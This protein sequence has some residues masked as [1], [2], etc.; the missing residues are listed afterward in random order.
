M[1]N[2]IFIEV[3]VDDKGTL[4]KVALDTKKL[5]QALNETAETGKHTDR[6]IKGVAQ[7]SSNATKNFSKMSQG[8]T[9]GLVPAYA[10][11]AA[12]VFALT[13]AFDF[14]KNAAD[15]QIMRQGQLQFAETTGI[16][17]GSLTKKLQ[18]A[19]Q[20]MLSFKE[21]SQSAA[22]G[23]AIGFSA[24]Q[25]EDLAEGAGKVATA[26]GRSY[27]DSYDRLVRGISKAEPE[28][29]D[30]LGITLKL[31]E[32]KKNYAKALGL[33][34]DSLN[35][36]QQSQAVYLETMTKL[37]D[38]F[39]K[40][41]FKANPFV[42]LQKTFTN[43]AET[44]LQKIMPGLS[45]FANFL[46][47]NAKAAGIAFAAILG[48]V[49]I[50]IA[51]LKEGI[52]SVGSKL[53]KVFTVPGAKI[54]SLGKSLFSAGITSADKFIVKMNEVEASIKD[55]YSKRLEGVRSGAAG[56]IEGGAKSKSVAALA[57]G[58]DL[59]PAPLGK[60]KKDIDNTISK[61]GGSDTAASG[62]FKGLS[63]EQL[64]EFRDSLENLGEENETFFSKVKNT[65]RSTT[66]SSIK[67]IKQIP[68][69]AKQS[70]KAATT[71]A[72]K[73]SKDT[74]KKIKDIPAVTKSTFK[75]LGTNLKN[76]PKDGSRALK[77][78]IFRLD[79]TGKRGLDAGQRI[80]KGFAKTAV[81]SL[82]SATRSAKVL[83]MTLKGVGKAAVI[84][85]KAFKMM[86]K[87]TVIFAVL[88][89][90]Y[91]VFQQL[92]SAPKTLFDTVISTIASIVRGV[93]TLGNIL[94]DGINSLLSKI[95]APL[96]ETFGLNKEDLVIG[97][98]TFADEKD[99]KSLEERLVGTVNKVAQNITGNENF[100]VRA[101]LDVIQT[102]NTQKNKLKALRDSVIAEA[103]DLA[104][105]GGELPRIIEGIK[106]A[107]TELEAFKNRA[108]ALG[109]L[110]IAS[111]VEKALNADNL[112]DLQQKFKSLGVDL[113]VLGPKFK[114]AF[115]AGDVV[116][117]KT[118]ST[119]AVG[120]TSSVK[121][122]SQNLN[123]VKEASQQGTHSFI[124]FLETLRDTAKD[125]DEMAVTLEGVTSEVERVNKAFK[126][127]GGIN[128]F[129]E[130]LTSLRDRAQELKLD[131]ISLNIKQEQG[132]N[133]T[134]LERGELSKTLELEKARLALTETRL[135]L[136]DNRIKQI[137]ATR[138]EKQVLKEQEQQLQKTIELRS[139]AIENIE[140]ATSSIGE[141]EMSVKDSFAGSLESAFNG[142][143]TGTMSV[144]E[145][146]ASMATSIL[147]SL[148]KIV[149]Q[150]LALSILTSM[151]P[152]SF[153]AGA[154][155]SDG[156]TGGDL[157]SSIVGGYRY[158]GVV[159]NS[160]KVPGYSTGGIA[161][162]RQSG[163]PAI[164]H[165]TEAVV[166]LPNG[167]SIPVEMKNSSSQQNNI[168]VNIS[169]E[170]SMST[171]Q[172]NSDAQSE[173]LG[174]AIAVAVQKEL[175]NQKRSGGILNPYGVS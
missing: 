157:L 152:G 158:G 59:R 23:T 3:A 58:E 50:N 167:K 48:M 95:P 161:K 61:M 121:T 156:S 84:A 127:Q 96:L 85:G 81:I 49:L 131:E 153:G 79:L 91:D 10:S 166:P 31:E 51:G 160:T 159:S 125:S 71:S 77:N 102:E 27:T 39:G 97:S 73:F 146:F 173:G 66:E 47:S 35:S 170:G 90:L 34:A 69:N 129:I 88:Q 86:T 53:V 122:I 112:E 151:I 113:D 6:N 44:V 30:E 89:Q 38:Q 18:E 82:K 163:Y 101:S 36:A 147:Q 150:R 162:G 5:R 37:K 142:I 63:K 169:S 139:L 154:G 55:A 42:Q 25:L 32:A 105:V 143:I 1:A 107:E 175:Q 15:T 123:D 14:L 29:L 83:R 165:G 4:K 62:V 120:Y 100:D 22:I 136:E 144:K 54:G 40:Q 78:F 126:D 67:N 76:A 138:N 65:I 148:A 72:T 116:T 26:L 133:L 145:A 109:S 93:Q 172:S 132:K 80:K 9:G 64:K 19:S 119:E 94:I 43:L 60:L 52:A 16:A 174:R 124:K 24:S 99:G 111:L 46:N 11:V 74:V 98:L 141:L 17:L 118:L 92:L 115:E 137:N 20:G 168:V 135:S 2:K 171:N 87:A 41:D 110:P 56:L 134:S 128:L 164:L 8:M 13:A 140:Y 7:A 103:E 106:N 28:L 70:F 75:N 114:K 108:N 21:A 104:G 130:R 33:N 117:L 68:S 45:T 155:V 57:A 149:S 12:Q